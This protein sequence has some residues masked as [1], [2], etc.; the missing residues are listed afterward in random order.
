MGV[1]STATINGLSGW[2]DEQNVDLAYATDE[3]VVDLAYA[4]DALKVDNYA[5]CFGPTWN[6]VPSNSDDGSCGC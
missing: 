1:E 2:I 5:H 6:R 3:Q 4:T